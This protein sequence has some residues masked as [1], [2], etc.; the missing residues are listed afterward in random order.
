MPRRAQ[1]RSSRPSEIKCR[2]KSQIQ[3]PRTTDVRDVIKYIGSK[4]LLGP[5]IVDVVSLLGECSSVV[6]L[7]SGTSRVGHALEASGY[8]MLA[9]DLGACAADR[10]P[11]N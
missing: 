6:D 4:R 7:F 2:R 5:L 1:T 3:A 10:I 8:R 9:N 11:L